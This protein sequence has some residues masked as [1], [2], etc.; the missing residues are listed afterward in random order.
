MYQLRAEQAMQPSFSEAHWTVR[1][2]RLTWPE[3]GTADLREAPAKLLQASA[4]AILL[5]SAAVLSKTQRFDLDEFRSANRACAL[6]LYPYLATGF[7][8]TRCI[9]PG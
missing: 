6:R 1:D 7:A 8:S 5:G 9:H 2:G 4:D 3:V